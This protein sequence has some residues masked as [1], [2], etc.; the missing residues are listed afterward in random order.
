[1]RDHGGNLDTARVRYGDGDWIDLS[2]GINPRPYPVLDLPAH[3]WT[4]LP[5]RAAMTALAE[6]A[7]GAYGTDTDV[8]PLAGA[9][10][11]IQ[12]IPRIAPR[13]TARVVGP[14]YNEHRGALEQAGWSVEEVRDLDALRGAAL[15]IVVNPNNPDGRCWTAEA[16]LDVVDDVGL[17]VC[18][19]SFGDIMP[20]AS[21]APHLKGV[22][23]VIVLRSFG[24]FYGLAG[25]R[26]GFAVCAAPLADAFRA[27]AGPWPVSGPAIHIG[28]RALAD[29]EW[30]TNTRKRLAHDADR[31]DAMAALA[32]WRLVGGCDLFRT[33]DTGDA[34]A[35]QKRLARHHIWSRIFPYSDTWLRLGL[36]DGDTNW[37]RLEAALTGGGE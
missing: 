15:A 20:G 3:A 21:L 16:L 25:V 29:T 35:A 9:Q 4:A 37:A 8:V 36:T 34:V 23:N 19:E 32:G 27:E 26:L 11:A 33:Y 13:G 28:A 2:T 1:M 24:K 22:A 18:D 7:R 31:L 5:T 6:A 10:A 12:M 30:Q 14:T 17:L